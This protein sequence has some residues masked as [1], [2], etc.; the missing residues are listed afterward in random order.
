[1]LRT[2]VSNGTGSKVRDTYKKFNEIPIVGKTG[3]TQN[4]GDVWFMGYSPDVT[5]GVWVGYREQVNT[6]VGDQRK[7]A[8]SIILAIS[9]ICVGLVELIVGGILPLI[10]EDL[11]I[12][13]GTAGQLITVF[14]WLLPN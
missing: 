1:M 2:V 3:S 5:L 12:S 10:A 8:Q 4:Y 9:T 6:L 11:H 7:H 13:L 14:Y